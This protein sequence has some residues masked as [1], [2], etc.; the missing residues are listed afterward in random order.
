[1]PGRGRTSLL[2][3]PPHVGSTVRLC[4]AHMLWRSCVSM[5]TPQLGVGPTFLAT[6]QIWELQIWWF[7][8]LSCEGQV[9]FCEFNLSQ[10]FEF[11]PCRIFSSSRLFSTIS[12]LRVL[13]SSP[14]KLSISKSLLRNRFPPPHR[15]YLTPLPCFGCLKHISSWFYFLPHLVGV[16]LVLFLFCS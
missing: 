12:Y 6:L 11:L 1:M 8:E 16:H 10:T 4:G 13:Y 3:L 9:L 15:L 5:L 7:L 14:T 2:P